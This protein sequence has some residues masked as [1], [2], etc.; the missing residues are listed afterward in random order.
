MK[1]LPLRRQAGQVAH[2][3]TIAEH[4]IADIVQLDCCCEATFFL[5][6]FGNGISEKA[7]DE[8]GELMDVTDRAGVFRTVELEV[9]LL[10]V[11]EFPLELGLLIIIKEPG[12]R[13]YRGQVVT[14][15]RFCQDRVQSDDVD[16][17]M[18]FEVDKRII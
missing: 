16:D 15:R 10:R 11:D 17:V 9:G 14:L 4:Q 12:Y 18:Q 7:E 13:I 1:E 6:L 8:L 5:E 2:N 3:C